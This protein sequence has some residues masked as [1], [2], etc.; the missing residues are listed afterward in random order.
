MLPTKVAMSGLSDLVTPLGY[1]PNLKVQIW[2]S[3][4]SNVRKEGKA[5]KQASICL[6]NMTPFRLSLLP[7]T[8]QSL[9]NFNITIHFILSNGPFVLYN[10]KVDNLYWFEFPFH[11]RN[12]KP[13]QRF[14]S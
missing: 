6:M 5:S 4:P 8:K 14:D 2:K 7:F 12:F 13:L 1:S 10:V 9:L 11:E 3:L